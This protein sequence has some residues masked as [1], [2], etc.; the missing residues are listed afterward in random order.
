MT[1]IAA[2]VAIAA[3]AGARLKKSLPTLNL[4]EAPHQ[5]KTEQANPDK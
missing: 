4:K 3:V 2:A 1:G 5:S